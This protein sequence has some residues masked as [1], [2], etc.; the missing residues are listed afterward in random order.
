MPCNGYS[1]CS[2]KKIFPYMLLWDVRKGIAANEMIKILW[3]VYFVV[4]QRIFLVFCFLDSIEILES[5]ENDLLSI[6][7]FCFAFFH[8]LLSIC[9]TQY[10][11]TI[12]A[13]TSIIRLFRIRTSENASD[14][15]DYV[16]NMK[17]DMYLPLTRSLACGHLFILWNLNCIERCTWRFFLLQI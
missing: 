7:E 12:D 2:I 17:S 11:K 13:N 15:A 14:M 5:I 3:V 1:N 8:C 16:M 10:T 6:A 4:C 9:Q